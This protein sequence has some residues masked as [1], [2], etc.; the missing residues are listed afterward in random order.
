MFRIV[1]K[2]QDHVDNSELYINGF[3]C[4]VLQKKIFIFAIFFVEIHL[5]YGNR[6]QAYTILFFAF[7]VDVYN[8]QYI[9]TTRSF[10]TLVFN[11]LVICYV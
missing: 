2:A 8:K 9:H 6:S 4:D 3:Y 5:L 10:K 7:K 1:H 11:G